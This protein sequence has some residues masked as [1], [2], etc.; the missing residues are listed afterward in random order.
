MPVCSRT[1][2]CRRTKP[3]PEGADYA[4]SP[5]WVVFHVVEHEAGHSFQIRE[6]K[7]RWSETG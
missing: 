5:A 6:I 3:E 4:C 7:R 2:A 1:G